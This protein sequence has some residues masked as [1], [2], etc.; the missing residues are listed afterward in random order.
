MV[1][2]FVIQSCYQ[3]CRLKSSE[4]LTPSEDFDGGDR[5]FFERCDANPDKLVLWR[6]E[7]IAAKTKIRKN[8]DPIF[9]FTSTHMSWLRDLSEIYFYISNKKIILHRAKS[10]AEFSAFL[11]RRQ[12]L[13]FQ[14]QV[15]FSCQSTW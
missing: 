5:E 4:D 2:P 1:S 3:I 7:S 15:L 6:V 8:S 13:P 11:I 9:Y 10:I 12:I 14:R